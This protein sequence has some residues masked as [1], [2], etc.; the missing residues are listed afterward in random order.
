MLRED[1]ADLRL[2]EKG[3]ELGLVDD[4]RWEHFSRKLELI[5][6]ERQRLRDIWV[7]PKSGSHDEV[8]EIL[9]VP[10]SKEANGEDLLRRPEMNYTLLTSIDRFHQH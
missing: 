8:N 7:N 4:V 9:A 10:L 1:N 3:R 2:T 6:K 5:E